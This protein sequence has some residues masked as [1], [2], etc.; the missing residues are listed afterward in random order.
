[1]DVSLKKLIL[2]YD[3]DMRIYD[4]NTF[5]C[6]HWPKDEYSEY[7]IKDGGFYFKHIEDPEFRLEDDTELSKG[8]IRAIF[9]AIEEHMTSEF[10]KSFL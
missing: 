5:R 2:T 1:M 7:Y 3:N 9:L 4:D 10:E 8:R 6:E